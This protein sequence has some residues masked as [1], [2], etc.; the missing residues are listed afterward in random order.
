MQ[1]PGNAALAQALAPGQVRRFAWTFKVDWAL[2]SLYADPNSDLSQCFVEA[3]I[4]R[5]LTGNYPEELEVTEGYAAAEMTVRLEGDAPDGTPLVRLFSPYSGLNVGVPAIA[6][7]PC[8][9]DVIVMTSAGPVGIRQFSGVVRR[10]IPVRASGSVDLVLRDAAALLQGPISVP[11]WAVDARLRRTGGDAADSG[12]VTMSWLIDNVLRRAPYVWMQGPPWHPNVIMAWTLNGSALPEVGNFAVLD[13]MV[14]GDYSSPGGYLDYQTP[15][16]T[17]AGAIAEVYMS[18][19]DGQLAFRGA[20]MTNWATKTERTL[21]GNGHT[22]ALVNPFVYGSNDSNLVGFSWRVQIDPAQNVAGMQPSEIRVHFEEPR[23]SAAPE[24]TIAANAW[25]QF[26]HGTGVVNIRFNE[27]GWVKAWQ[28]TATITPAPA[29]WLNMYAVLSFSSTGVTPSLVVNGAVV[30]LGVV[31]YPAWPPAGMAYPFYANVT[32]H[33]RVKASGP[34]NFAQVFY[35]HNVALGNVVVPSYTAIGAAKVDVSSLRLMWIPKQTDQMTWGL[36][37]ELAKAELGV[38]YVDE[39]G[40]VTFDNRTTVSARQTIANVSLT[41]T[42]RQLQDVSPQT[43]LESAINYLTWELVSRDAELTIYRNGGT[44]APA[45]VPPVFAASKVDQ[46]LVGAGV[47]SSRPFTLGNDIMQIQIGPVTYEPRSMGYLAGGGANPDWQ[48]WMQYYAPAT[49][50]H[51]YTP[52]VPGS[53]T[54]PATQPVPAGGVGAG[55]VQG[56]NATD[57]DPAHMLLYYSNSGA[58]TAQYSIDD[59]T[60]FLNVGGVRIMAHDN[61]RQSIYDTASIAVYGLRVL[62]LQGGSWFQDQTTVTPLAQSLLG[63]VVIPHPFLQAVAAPGD[64]RTQLQDVARINDP[65]VLGGPI[66]ASVVGIK[67]VVSKREGVRDTY[68]LRTFGSIGGSWIMGDPEFSVMGK[69][70]IV[71]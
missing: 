53:R 23:Y 55:V 27:H 14:T 21:V 9:L 11:T 16:R 5:Q 40:V 20:T 31:A 57:T 13:E 43:L 69:T 60:P 64:P 68:T 36:L 41:L 4:D 25:I 8:Y 10:A 24:G 18:A 48:L 28:W 54:N 6:G 49:I 70:T 65:D 52:Y 50:S 63:D 32:N 66:F 59:S 39:Y 56:F 30:A 2:D 1:F 58:V 19:P 35:Q 3:T 62:S 33:S 26:N 61:D 7:T 12:T 67:R 34:A 17:P 42:L 37:R 29:R 71:S 46:F 47:G 15:N 45:S 22:S 38:M 44:I 51:G